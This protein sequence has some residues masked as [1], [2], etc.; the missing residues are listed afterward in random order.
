[1]GAA[2]SLQ[3]FLLNVPTDIVQAIELE[4]SGLDARFSR[5][6]WGPAE[7][8]G[9]RFAEA[10]FRYLE[11]KQSGT[12]T[13]IGTQINRN[14]I[15][16]RVSNDVNLPEGLRFHVLKCAEILLDIRN[17]RNVAHLGATINVDEMDSRLVLRLT[18]WVL[19][20]VIREESSAT[21][22]DIQVI[23]DKLSTKEIPLVE[24]IDGDLIIVG[25]HLK[26]QERTLIALYH[27]YPNP[28]PIE[29]LQNTIKYQNTSRFRD[30]ILAEQTKEGITHIKD[31]KVFLTKKGCAWVEKYIDMRLEI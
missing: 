12:F 19:S 11:W 25:T 18:K 7:L 14:N 24:E 22:K 16:N 31:G 21:P 17:K 20:E 2:Y 4:F 3:N 15:A 8:N 30:E 1:M 26:A 23:V 28:L 5:N 27:T 29:V 9:A 10:I 6:D 13:A